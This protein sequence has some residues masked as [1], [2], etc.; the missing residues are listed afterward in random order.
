LCLFGREHLGGVGSKMRMADVQHVL[1]QDAGINRI[2]VPA[3]LG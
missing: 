2:D 3:C 1:Q